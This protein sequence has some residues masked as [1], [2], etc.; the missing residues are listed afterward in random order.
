MDHVLDWLQAYHDGELHGQKAHW[1]EAHLSHCESCRAELE[2]LQ[3]FSSLLQLSS[4]APGLLRPE[5]F[6]DQVAQA[7][8]PLPLHPAPVALRRALETGWHLIPVGLFGAWVFVQTAYIVIAVMLL[9]QSLPWVAQLFPFTLPSVSG[10]PWLAG[11]QCV[12]KVGFEA[13]WCIA[14]FGGVVTLGFGPL[15]AIALL[16]WAWLAAWW[17]RQ[18]R[19]VTS[20]A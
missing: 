15:V 10:I 4:P 7:T 12:A 5:S 9:A 3:A 20:V 8:S 16:Y 11:E 2:A 14:G 17:L 19:R 18:Q 6:V 13:L 1:V